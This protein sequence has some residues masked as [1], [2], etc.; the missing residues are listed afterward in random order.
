[1]SQ[2]K[3][4]SIAVGV[5]ALASMIKF[6]RNLSPQLMP[7]L[8]MNKQKMPIVSLLKIA[9]QKQD[10][11]TLTLHSL[12]LIL[13][14]WLSLVITKL[15]G[16]IVKSLV[17]GRLNQFIKSMG[18]W[19]ALAVPCSLTNSI[20]KYLQ[21]KL[22]MG[23][24][25]NLT[26]YS[27]SLYLDK[28]LSFYKITND[29]RIESIDQYLTTDINQFCQSVTSLYSNLCKPVLDMLLFNWQLKNTIGS[30]GTISLFF[31]YISTAQLLR[32]ISPSFGKA[33]SRQAHLEGHYRQY[34]TN[35]ITNAEEICFY[36][37]E[38][39]EHSMLNKVYNDLQNHIHSILKL[40]VPYNMVEDIFVKYEW[41]AAALLVCGIPVFFKSLAPMQLEEDASQHFVIAKRLMLSL[42][43]AGG[44]I[45]Y[46]YKDLLEVTGYVQRLTHAI[47]LLH[48][49]HQD[50]L[51]PYTIANQ[52]Q[53]T[54]ATIKVPTATKDVVIKDLNVVIKEKQHTLITGPNG[55][56]KTAIVRCLQQLW[57]LE[58]HMERSLTMMSIPQ[59]AYLPLGTLRDQLIYPETHQEMQARG[60]TDKEL[61]QFLDHVHLGYLEQREGGFDTIKDWKDVLSGGE[62]QRVNLCRL[63]YFMPKWAI[64]DECSS[65]VSSDVEG[66][67]YKLLKDNGMTLI[68]V[69]HRPALFKY[70]GH[71]LS[72][73]GDGQWRFDQIGTEEEETSIENEIKV[74]EDKIGNVGHLKERLRQ[75]NKELGLRY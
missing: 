56:G 75:I 10:I 51:T 19:C 2:L 3:N 58:G 62:K 46:A 70:H 55:S 49:M 11:Y 34:H 15:D 40:K 16:Q 45:M 64:L 41:S 14:T 18:I 65:A 17:K 68:T 48:Q 69:S 22:A 24:R 1:M 23:M 8:F 39:V 63:F 21:S 7:E 67:I 20:I 27:L 30:F 72:L 35:L 28:Q 61:H 74:L 5:L 6:K 52:V 32:F 44:R 57:T 12:F 53:F 29:S 13:R 42:G 71:L 26:N 54:D 50:P 73:I 66:L 25:L 37:G 38:N 36:N 4:S 31:N 9:F 59:R 60:I 43:E 47:T 33:A